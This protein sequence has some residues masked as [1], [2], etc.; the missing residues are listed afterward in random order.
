M[1]GEFQTRAE[2]ILQFATRKNRSYMHTTE[3]LRLSTITSFML[4]NSVEVLDDLLHL[5]TFPFIY[6]L[7][8][9]PT[10]PAQSSVI[11]SLTTVYMQ[12]LDDLLH[13]QHSHSFRACCIIPQLLHY[14]GWRVPCFAYVI[15]MA[16]C[17]SA[18]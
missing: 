12:V 17:Q 5:T 2:K 13:L 14:T 1:Y 9:H 11:V 8:L 4:H 15:Y 18:S 16:M 10:T 3:A 6:S 7:L